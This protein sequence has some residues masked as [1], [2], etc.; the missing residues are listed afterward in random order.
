MWPLK[1]DEE[2]QE[3]NSDIVCRGSTLRLMPCTP[4]NGPFVPC[5]PTAVGNARWCEHLLSDGISDG[6]AG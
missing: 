2:E 5:H 4:I 1:S 6:T 3:M